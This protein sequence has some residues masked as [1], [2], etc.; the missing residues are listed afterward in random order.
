M[1][2]EEPQILSEYPSID[3]SQSGCDLRKQ[4]GVNPA[5]V[6]RA[7]NED[8]EEIEAEGELCVTPLEWEEL[9]EVFV[10]LNEEMIKCCWITEEHLDWEVDPV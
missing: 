2:K 9:T 6:R 3:F 7:G 1:Y 10:I 5:A 8:T 4:E